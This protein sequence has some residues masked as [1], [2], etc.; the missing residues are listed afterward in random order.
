[1]WYTQVVI[2]HL[3]HFFS[4]ETFR[5]QRFYLLKKNLPFSSDQLQ[6]ILNDTVKLSFCTEIIHLF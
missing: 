5:N 3:K 4:E 2:A 6:Y 1:M